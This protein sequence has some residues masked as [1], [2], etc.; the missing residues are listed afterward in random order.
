[1]LHNQQ[2]INN[3][4]LGVAD[5]YLSKNKTNLGRY[6]IESLRIW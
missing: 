6:V 3:S 4:R 5:M 1:M 2:N